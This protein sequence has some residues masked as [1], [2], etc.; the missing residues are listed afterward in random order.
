M[1]DQRGGRLHF[2]EPGKPVQNAFAESFNGRFRDE[3][4]NASWFLSLAEARET[5][6]AYRRD[7]NTERPHSSLRGLTPSEYAVTFLPQTEGQLT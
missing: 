3:C 4:L 7:F 5:V 6:A 1:A 2:I